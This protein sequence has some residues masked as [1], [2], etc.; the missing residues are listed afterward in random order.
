MRR[1]CDSLIDSECVFVFDVAESV[2]DLQAKI[3]IEVGQIKWSA[4]N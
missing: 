3:R 2:G 4:K 1:E